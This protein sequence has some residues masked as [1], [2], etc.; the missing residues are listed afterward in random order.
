M[1]FSNMAKPHPLGAVSL[2]GD[3]NIC[4]GIW[5]PLL[6]A[7]KKDKFVEFLVELGIFF[8]L[9]DKIRVAQHVTSLHISHHDNHITTMSWLRVLLFM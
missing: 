4:V 6:Y 3:G 9:V 2:Y 1:H 5:N 7:L 8:S